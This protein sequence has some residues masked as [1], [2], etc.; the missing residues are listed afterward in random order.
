LF[1]R[2]KYTALL[3]ALLLLLVAHPLINANE[4]FLALP[5]GL[6]LAAVF[7]VVLLTLFQRKQSRV[8]GL[9]LGIPAIAG[10]FTHY[11]LPGMPPVVAARF[12]HLAA[13]VFLCY[14]V[15]TI[16]KVL[17][18]E[19][20]VS[21][22]TINAAF[23]GYLLIGLA[24]DD[25]RLRPHHS[26]KRPGPDAGL[27]RSCGRAVLRRRGHRRTGRPPGVRGHPRATARPPPGLQVTGRARCQT[28]QGREGLTF[29][30]LRQP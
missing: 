7:L 3:L 19:T 11:L 20:D 12:L 8:A 14:T 24:F 4:P 27:G 18:V 15:T 22:D 6:L 2:W 29:R 10:V 13:V 5:Y 30:P 26:P 9:V 25:A 28:R 21:A 23:C 17:L 1:N 16:L